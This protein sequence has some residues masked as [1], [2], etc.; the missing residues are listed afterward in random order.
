MIAKKLIKIALLDLNHMTLGIHTKTVPLGSGLIKKYIQDNITDCD[1]RLFKDYKKLVLALKDWIPDIVGLAQYSWN[2]E[3]NYFMAQYIRKLN[4]Y[5][6]IVA[7]GP[8]QPLDKDMKV[9]ICIPFDGEIPFLT[10]MNL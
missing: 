2:S 4:P 7:G 8:N 6:W 10:I 5:C 9:D 1:I 3:L